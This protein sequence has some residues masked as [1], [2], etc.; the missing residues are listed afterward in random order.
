MQ[1][2]TLHLKNIGPFKDAE[3][4]FIGESRKI[5][6]TIITGENGAGK[7]IILDAIRALLAGYL[8]IEMRN[9]LRNNDNF[10]IDIELFYNDKIHNVKS[11]KE[12]I[13]SI[14]K[15]FS[16]DTNDSELAN[17]FISEKCS[18]SNIWITNYWTSRTD[19][20]QYKISNLQFLIPE[21]YLINS[22]SG[23]QSNIEVI[24]LITYFDYLKS[25]DNVK[26][27]EEGEFLFNTLKKIIKL[28]LIDGEFQ[29][30]ERK[31]LIPIISQNGVNVS[32]DKLSS[33]N[34]YLIQRMIS[35]LGQMYSVYTLNNLKLE[36]MLLT[37]GLLMI[38]EAENHLHPKWQKTFLNS[39]L[40]IFPNLQLIVTT[41]SP[42]IV[43]SVENA[44][45]YVCKPM[46][47]HSIVVDET[48]LYSNKPIDEI[49]MSDIF[50]TNP[51]NE[52]ISNLMKERI[53]AI[54]EG[55]IEKSTNIETE[56]KKINPQYFSY[57]D[58][59]TMLKTLS[60]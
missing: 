43:S 50:N 11:N 60:K 5:P 16:L 53:E 14:D 27:R 18:K 34:L 52:A 54:N 4:D 57:F 28:S 55:N 41:H 21:N 19:N 32:L 33:G 23:I 36:E 24:Q 2:N 48:S 1:I 3:I 9:I 37:P 6:I 58:I 42:F 15:K 31:T 44:R 17:K 59:D 20:K 13:G 29:Y 45:I 26:E 35:L 39:I 38:D 8:G 7:T 49:L 40:E 22:L 56:L 30:V 51:F 47:D 12:Y 46:I 25:S 10:L